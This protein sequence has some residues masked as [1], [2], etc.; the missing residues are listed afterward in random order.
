[1][2][3]YVLTLFPEMIDGGV[4]HSIVKRAHDKGHI[5]LNSVNIRD[6]AGNKHGKVD[7]YPYGGGTGLV[8]TPQPV[9][10]AY[11]SLGVPTGTRVVYLTPKGRPFEQATA[12]ALAQETDMVLLCGHY[13]G[14]DQRVLDLIVTDEI[15][16]GDYVLTGGELAACV[17]IDAVTR[18]LPGVLKP[19]ATRHESFENNLL[20]HPHYTRPAMF[21]GVAVPAVLLEG[22]HQKINDF[23]KEK[24]LE[25][26]QQQR[27]DLLERQSVERRLP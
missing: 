20:E 8:M 3:F 14:I 15:S 4:N 12:K 16:I 19:D 21:R 27:P 23:R 5:R 18:L 26:T 25:L 24:S 2:N 6:F 9:Y 22:H 10:D 17:I 7:D 1:M 13:E 11:Q